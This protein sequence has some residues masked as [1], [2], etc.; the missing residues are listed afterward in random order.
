MVLALEM[1]FPSTGRRDPD[2][3]LVALSPTVAFTA[4]PP[5]DIEQVAN[6]G[7]P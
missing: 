3:I 2:L 5:R 6:D 7:I 4:P 1:T